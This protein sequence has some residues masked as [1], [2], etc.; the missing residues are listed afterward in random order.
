MRII[1]AYGP[2]DP[3]SNFDITY[4]SNRRGTKSVFLTTAVPDLPKI[5]HD[6]TT[7]DFLMDKVSKL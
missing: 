6:A 7:F 4:H 2:D 1:F 5:P 3:R